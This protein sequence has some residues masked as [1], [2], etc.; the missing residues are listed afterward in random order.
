MG[1]YALTQVG[2]LAALVLGLLAFLE[3]GLTGRIVILAVLLVSFFLQRASSS[4]TMDVTCTVIWL[5]FGASCFIFLR[6][7]KAI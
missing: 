6:Y 2:I 5:L 1:T 3:S 7:R 4:S